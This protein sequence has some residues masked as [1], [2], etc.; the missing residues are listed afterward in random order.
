MAISKDYI[1]KLTLALYKVTDLF[2]E[3]E[4]LKFSIRKKA[5][6]VLSY[7]VLIESNPISLDK[8]E[9]AAIL[10]NGLKETE[11]L[12]FYFQVAEEQKW[13]DKRNFLVLKRE[14]RKVQ[15]FLGRELNDSPVSKIVKEKSADRIPIKRLEKSRDG[16]SSIEKQILRI[17]D[18]EGSS[19]TDKIGESLSGI[20]S[21]YI[22][23]HLKILRENGFIKMN[24][25]GREI[26]YKSNK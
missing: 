5:N 20:S 13:L 21:R 24:K 9:R 1:I 16:L 6:S 19:K 8:E 15:E 10:R 23:K 2:P 25:I 14:Y 11:V 3:R 7:L 26:F 4:P 12:E 17:L 18:K 22:R